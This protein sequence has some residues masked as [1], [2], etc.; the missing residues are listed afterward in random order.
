M[1]F[2]VFAFGAPNFHYLKQEC[3]DESDL[4]TIK[5][6][7]D[8][9]SFSPPYKGAA[10]QYVGDNIIPQKGVADIAAN[11]GYMELS[12]LLCECIDFLAIQADQAS[13]I[14]VYTQNPHF[15]WTTTNSYG[16]YRFS[17]GDNPGLEFIKAIYKGIKN[18]DMLSLGVIKQ[19]I[20]VI[21]SY[22]D[23]CQNLNEKSNNIRLL[24]QISNHAK[25]EDT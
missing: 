14:S 13:C 16:E 23:Y 15:L 8:L 11:I 3:L 2:K 7:Y 6:L 25:S 22:G 4:D 20:A 10:I 18:N 19:I 21:A 17:P 9:S 12:H 24:I 1:S 5:F